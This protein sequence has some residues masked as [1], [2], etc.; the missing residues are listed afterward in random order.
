ML[1]VESEKDF[2]CVESAIV[3]RHGM[4]QDRAAGQGG[5]FA[6]TIILKRTFPYR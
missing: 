4:W 1:G 3:C 2:A 6:R 5:A